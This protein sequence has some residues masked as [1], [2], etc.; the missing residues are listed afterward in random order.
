M[1]EYVPVEAYDVMLGSDGFSTTGSGDPN[2]ASDATGSATAHW[3]LDTGV[4]GKGWDLLYY[5]F[6]SGT[7]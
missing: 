4:T 5:D 7:V 3:N 6:A 1:D 2:R